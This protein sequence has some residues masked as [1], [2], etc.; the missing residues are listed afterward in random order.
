ME[1]KEILIFIFI[2]ERLKKF[3][4]IECLLMVRVE[5]ADLVESPECAFKY[6]P[7]NAQLSEVI[8][9]THGVMLRNIT[10]NWIL[11]ID[12]IDQIRKNL[13]KKGFNSEAVEKEI[14]ML[15]SR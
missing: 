11:N 5:G 12:S 2:T 6:L 10:L 1:E 15:K 7:P 14:E 3:K 13:L 8:D 4:G 9:F